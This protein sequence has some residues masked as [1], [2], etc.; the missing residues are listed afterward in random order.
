MQFTDSSHRA[1]SQ[2]GRPARQIFGKRPFEY[3]AFWQ[4][5]IFV[6]LLCLVWVNEVL[7][8]P[9]LI[10]STPA[11]SVN[12]LGA[13]ILTVC[14][15]VVGFISIAYSYQQQKRVLAGMITICSYCN[16][17]QLDEAAWQRLDLFVSD[18][19]RAEF[20]HGVC[21]ECFA[22][23]VETERAKKGS[24]TAQGAG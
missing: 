16:R 23:V 2:P 20:S 19:T 22:K 18:K 14:V 8:L 7:D 21:P 10:Y 24:G 15:V 9:N 5:L 12:W 3:I 11:S 6:M 13:S 4:F 1:M 17:V